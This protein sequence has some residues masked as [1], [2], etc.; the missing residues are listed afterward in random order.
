MENDAGDLRVDMTLVEAIDNAEEGIEYEEDDDFA[1][2]GDIVA[3]LT[4]V[5]TRGTGEADGDAGLKLREKGV[6]NLNAKLFGVES[7]NNLVDGI[8][9]REDSDGS[10]SAQ[11]Q[12]MTTLLNNGDGLELD[13]NSAGN[14]NVVVKKATS[15]NN[16]LGGVRADQAS[17]GT[18]TLQLV[19]FTASG[20]GLGAVVA[21]AGVT[22]TQTP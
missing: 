13:E 14:L 2:G 7:S 18:G 4:G 1:G 9:L 6:G 11:L 10:L 3:T 15:S 12:T 16:V 22:V 8:L 17:P 19:T 21:N 20:N 5:K